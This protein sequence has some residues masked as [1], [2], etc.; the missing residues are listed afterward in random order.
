MSWHFSTGFSNPALSNSA[1]TMGCD[2]F[3]SLHD[4]I[5]YDFSGQVAQYEFQVTI[6]EGCNLEA[7]ELNLDDRGVLIG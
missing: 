2:N 4:Y 5:A 3:C 1:V 7:S 6:K